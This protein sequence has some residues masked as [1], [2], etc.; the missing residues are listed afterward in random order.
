[1]H[2]PP[3]WPHRK[4][5]APA[6]PR[7]RAQGCSSPVRSRCGE[8]TGKMYDEWEVSAA[9]ACGDVGPQYAPRWRPRRIRCDR[10]HAPLAEATARGHRR[11]EGVTCEAATAPRPVH[12]RGWWHVPARD[13]RMVSSNGPRC[14]LKPTLH[15]MGCSPE[16]ATPPC[17]GL[18]T[19]GGPSGAAVLTEFPDWRAGPSAGTPCST[20]NARGQT[21]RSPKSPAS[22][23]VP[24]RAARRRA[25]LRRRALAL[26]VAARPNQ[27]T[28][29]RRSRFNTIIHK[30]IFLTSPTC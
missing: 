5:G 21:R 17:A 13:R 28:V 27:G 29:A 19:G 12:D 14:D 4:A 16:H 25:D 24:T 23:G 20:A 18:A 15:R 26:A 10:C 7:K 2:E 22:D 8:A 9:R 30:H 1:M 3:P 11:H 6:V